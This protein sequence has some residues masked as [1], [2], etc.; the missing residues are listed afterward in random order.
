MTWILLF[1]ICVTLYVSD[2][3]AAYY[4]II[5]ARD[6]VL[7]CYSVCYVLFMIFVIAM[8]VLRQISS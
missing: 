6:H 2:R 4:N 8:S 3:I 1:M 7:I 5:H